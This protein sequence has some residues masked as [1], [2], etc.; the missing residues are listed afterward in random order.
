LVNEHCASLQADVFVCFFVCL[1]EIVD[2]RPLIRPQS[3][4]SSQNLHVH[5]VV[6]EL[7]VGAQVARFVCGGC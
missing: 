6:V 5:P 4:E 2:L 3:A 7:N 1:L